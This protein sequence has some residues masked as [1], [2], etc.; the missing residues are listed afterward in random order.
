[1]AT[2]EGARCRDVFEQTIDVLKKI[3]PGIRNNV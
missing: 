1:M 2:E 3:E